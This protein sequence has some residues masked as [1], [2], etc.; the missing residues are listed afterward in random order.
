MADTD[1]VPVVRVRLTSN[2]KTL[3]LN[4]IKCS[5]FKKKEIL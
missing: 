4:Q 2:Q 1:G 3:G 5:I